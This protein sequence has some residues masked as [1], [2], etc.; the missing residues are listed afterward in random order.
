MMI[1]VYQASPYMF[2]FLT[3]G[4]YRCFVVCKEVFL[5]VFDRAT[6]CLIV[7]YAFEILRL[8]M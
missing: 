3:D 6:T 4:Q 7:S 2:F 5:C 1:Y 8:I